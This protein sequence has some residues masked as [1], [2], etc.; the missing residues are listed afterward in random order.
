MSAAPKSALIRTL[1]TVPLRTEER[2]SFL[3]DVVTILESQ[4]MHVASNVTVRIDGRNFRVDILATAKT[5]GSVAIEID[6]SSPRPRSVMKLRE[7]ARRGTE[8]FVLL[9]MPK[10]LT[11]YS[12]A[13]IDI[14][15]ANGK[16][17]SC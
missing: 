17:A 12:D 1:S 8:G 13:G 6:R 3:A 5:G 4:G 9:R 2:Y 15:P 14:I 10:K 16:G 7:L 11:S